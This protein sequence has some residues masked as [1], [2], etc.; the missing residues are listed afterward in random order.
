MTKKTGVVLILILGLVLTA[1]NPNRVPKGFPKKDE[2]AKILAD[3]H[4]VEATI[5][6]FPLSERGVDTTVNKYYNFVL[7]KHNL[8]Q[9]KF[10]TI[11][12][13][14]LSHPA[15]YQQVYDKV[16]ALLAEKEAQCEREIKAIDDETKRILKQKQARNI[17][18]TD[19]NY[20]V[21]TTD[22][23][24]R[25]IPFL[26]GV[27]TIEARGYS[28]SASYQFLKESKIKESLIQVIALY[29]DSTMDTI[30][31][32]TPITHI[33]TKAELKIGFDTDKKI[34]QLEGFLMKHDT[35]QQI[36]AN[37]MNVEFEYVEAI[38]SLKPVLLPK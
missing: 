21:N 35:L 22:T 24:D 31:Y 13:W 38:D 36:R 32:S 6:Q 19:K 18:K 37:I 30:T 28:L 15:L 4:Q 5:N 26:I 7:D 33:N 17:W 25:Q 29:A 3:V 14:Y 16:I 23:F 34:I 10:D 12:S 11:V 8:T 1:C 20:F 9:Q 27:D 2:F